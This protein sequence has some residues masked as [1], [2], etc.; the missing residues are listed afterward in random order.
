MGATKYILSLPKTI[1]FNFKVFPIKVAV[2]L[3][4]FLHYN[5][6]IGSLP[7]GCIEIVDAPIRPGMIKFGCSMGSAGVFMGEYPA[8]S[9]GGYISVKP[10]C[11]IKFRGSAVFAGG[12]S[13]RLDNSGIADFGNNFRCNSYCF[14]AA[15]SLIKIGEG[16]VI[17]WN[18]NIRDVDGHHIYKLNDKERTFINEPRPVII[19]A[20][21]WIAA[22]VDIIK[23]TSIPDNSVIAY[24]SIIA[25]K[26]FE[27]GNCILG[28]NPIK[29]LKE[30]IDWTF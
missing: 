23:G 16:C 30:D 10:G 11:K 22:H 24:G 28:G 21:V 4:V 15:N 1:Y 17:G 18:V 20:H 7:K 19:G 2:K 29:V 3:P 6:K 9:G 13:L 5:V 8:H 14:I 26:K 12:I 25:G 27:K